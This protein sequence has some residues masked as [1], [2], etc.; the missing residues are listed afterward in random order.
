M[1]SPF[2]YRAN[3]PLFLNRDDMPESNTVL[4]LLHKDSSDLSYEI[5][6]LSNMSFYPYPPEEDVYCALQYLSGSDINALKQGCK[7]V[8]LP[9]HRIK[10][11]RIRSPK[12]VVNGK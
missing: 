11:L 7:N 3:S 9:L 6:V 10:G 2:A 12:A 1:T 8:G 4:I 5:P